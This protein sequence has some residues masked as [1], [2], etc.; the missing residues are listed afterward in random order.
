M[1][2]VLVSTAGAV[3]FVAGRT[4][5]TVLKQPWLLF[6]IIA[7]LVAVSTG[8]LW[9]PLVTLPFLLLSQARQQRSDTR[10]HL[11]AQ[12]GSRRAI[13]DMEPV[14]D[15]PGATVLSAVVLVGIAFLTEGSGPTIT[16]AW[17]MLLLGAAAIILVGWR[18][19]YVVFRAG[20]SFANE[21]TPVVDPGQSIEARASGRLL[22][23]NA[24]FR[25]TQAGGQ[26]GWHVVLVRGTEP[27]V[28]GPAGVRLKDVRIV[29][30]SAD[31][32]TASPNQTA[33]TRLLLVAP[34]GGAG[35]TLCRPDISS[36]EAGVLR[37]FGGDK[38]ALRIDTVVGPL[39]LSFET[40]AAMAA[41][42]GAIAEQ[43]G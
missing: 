32:P 42:R 33:T 4:V 2:D 34:D 13:Y 41:A 26:A 27:G 23:R 5:S 30:E 6:L 39:T 16:I 15:V 22:T 12:L 14:G 31:G 9:L 35:L 36:I 10:R 20:G 21:I 3:A 8:I 38:P 25:T 18:A 1:L 11:A 24:V 28:Y 7:S 37:Q 43:L 19:G 17:R 40:S 29:R